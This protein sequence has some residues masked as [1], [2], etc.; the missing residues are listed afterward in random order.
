MTGA[1]ARCCCLGGKGGAADGGGGGGGCSGRSGSSA[2][3]ACPPR[4]A[5][6]AAP[7]CLAAAAVDRGRGAHLAAA[8]RRRRALLGGPRGG[9]RRD[10]RRCR[11]SEFGLAQTNSS[12]GSAAE[13]YE[14]RK[15]DR[16]RRGACVCSARAPARQL[17]PALA[18]PCGGSKGVASDAAY[19]SPPPPRRCRT[20]LRAYTCRWTA[21]WP[22]RLRRPAWWPSWPSRRR[23]RPLFWRSRPWRTRRWRSGSQRRFSRSCP[24]LSPKPACVRRT[25]ISWG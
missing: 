16:T 3:R 10:C 24:F 14:G 12:G 7:G 17:P 25:G 6:P 11:V 15:H 19:P 23:C 4:P 21:L 2:S 20:N 8:P 1:R 22:A 5:P 13:R 9:G 18:E